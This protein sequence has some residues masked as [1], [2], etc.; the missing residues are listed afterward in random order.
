M[1]DPDPR[2]A[3]CPH[4]G[5]PDIRLTRREVLDKNL[6]RNGKQVWQHIAYCQNCSAQVDTMGFSSRKHTYHGIEDDTI[7]KWNRRDKPEEYT[8]NYQTIDE[9]YIDEHEEKRKRWAE[10]RRD[11]LNKNQ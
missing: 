5:N 11:H 1:S 3:P 10:N 9:P 2:L 6:T 7:D 4:C 8:P